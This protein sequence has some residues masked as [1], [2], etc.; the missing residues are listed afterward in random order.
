MS[1]LSL[2]FLGAPEVRSSG[3]ILTFRTRK[4]LALLIYL[5]V[6]GGMHSRESLT[7]LFWPESEEPQGRSMLRTTLARLRTALDVALERSLLIVERDALGFDVTSDVDLDLRTLEAAYTLASAQRD[8]TDGRQGILDQLQH[9]VHCYRDDFLEGFS[10]VD[11]PDFDD[12]VRLQREV[13]HRRMSAVFDALSHLQFTGGELAPAIDSSTRWVTHDP[14]NETAHQ[15]LMQAYFASGDRSAALQVYET[16]RA[17]LTAQLRIKPTPETE[18]L[19]DRIRIGTQ[20]QQVSAQSMPALQARPHP[21]T[22]PELPLIGRAKEYATLIEDYQRVL[23]GQTQVVV[24]KGEAGI[25]KTRLIVEF[26]RWVRVQ[27]ADILQGRAFEAESGLPYQ[28][29]IECLRSRIEQENAPDDLLSDLWLTEL[30]RILP[31]LHD[32]YPDLPSASMDETVAGTR[33]FEAVARLGE[34]LAERA[35]V[36][37]YVDDVQW[38]DAASLDML[39]YIGRRWAASARP[40]L[41]LLNLRTEALITTNALTRWLSSLQRDLSTMS[42]TLG[43]LTLED[44]VQLMRA[45]GASGGERAIGKLERFGRWLF[46]ETRGQPFYVTETLKALFERHLLAIDHQAD[47]R[48]SVHFDAVT[49]AD[50]ELR[51]LLPA[52]IRE[53]IHTRLSQLT[54]NAFALLAAGSVLD[55][56]FA[57]EQ[58]C[59]VAD[60]KDN[61]GLVAL[62]EVLTHRLLCEASEEESRPALGRYFFTHDKIRDVTYTEAGEARRR[63]FHRRAFEGLQEVAAPPATL[64]HHALAAGLVEPAFRWSVAAG[65]EAMRLSAVRDAIAHYEQ[66]RR[67]VA[68][69]HEEA[70]RS[71]LAQHTPCIASASAVQ[72]LYVQLG[73]AYELAPEPEQARFVYQAMLAYA[74]ETGIPAMEC[75]ALNRLATLIAHIDFDMKQA[76]EFLEQARAVAEQAGDT[77]SLAETEWSL[78]QLSLYHGDI[79][80]ILMYGEHALALARELNQQEL[81]AR[82][83]N[84]TAYGKAQARCCEEAEHLAEEALALYHA[85]GNRPMEADCLCLIASARISA[86]RPQAAVEAAR[87]AHSINMHIENTVGQLFSSFHLGIGLLETGAYAQ[88][89]ELAQRTL[90]IARTQNVPAFLPLSL[91]LMG[92]VRRTLLDV[93]AARTT[94][95]EAKAL[96]DSLGPHPFTTMIVE[97]LCAVHALAGAW[98]DAYTYAM[99]ELSSREGCIQLDTGLTLWYGT[100][101]L[102]RAGERERAAG[103][104]RRFGEHIGTSRRY[105]IPYL[106]ALSVLAE[107]RGEIDTAIAHVQE[108]AQLAEE[109]GLPGEMWSMWVALGE[110]YQKQGDEREANQTFARAAE[111]IQSLA[112]KMEDEQLRTTFLSA[113]LVQ[114]TLERARFL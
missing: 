16:C 44:T 53:V 102:L 17:T 55:H 47:G 18:A 92:K 95:L 2:S 62:D 57:F 26:L 100:E 13:W 49:R 8:H 110:M 54:P 71:M 61:K 114:H 50:F 79:P 34:A 97:E 99:Q 68:Q 6:A 58:L 43:P 52:S 21:S 75:L 41:L 83:L 30:A 59:R 15:R 94:Y 73:R 60:L 90:A 63:I 81:V 5:A 65:D 12:W 39:H 14:L 87:A 78:A 28:P 19:A 84:V 72:Q 40:V 4:T 108:A 82:C 42:L 89:Q 86:G 23:R 51:G 88:A 111:I 7:A 64:A 9:A 66:A 37:L 32:R 74:Q 27:G 91:I 48:W 11:A 106:R 35:P 112:K 10:L 96:N 98:A 29:L 101:A 67:L 103:E 31:E 36:V 80:A 38:A 93:D 85:L 25:G 20:L 22:L 46:A 45:V 56:G 69:A 113:R 33:L 77:S 105:R 109:M 24:L 107:F 70:P 104:V 1:Q 76:I 3:R